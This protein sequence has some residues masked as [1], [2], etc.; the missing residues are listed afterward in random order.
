MTHPKFF[1][2]RFPRCATAVA[3]CAMFT[4]AAAASAQTGGTA[5]STSPGSATSTTNPN[6]GNTA[7]VATSSGTAPGT[8]SRTN[9]PGSIDRND[10]AAGGD[11]MRDQTRMR[12]SAMER[13]NRALRESCRTVGGVTEC[14]DRDGNRIPPE[15]DSATGAGHGTMPGSGSGSTPASSQR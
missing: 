10:R 6:S 1:T 7:D 8:R 15:R 12:S 13:T 14:Y 11:A 5:G 3:A 2:T 9:T 4:I